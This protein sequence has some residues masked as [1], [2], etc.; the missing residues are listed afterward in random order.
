[1]EGE[2]SSGLAS[3]GI[4]IASAEPTLNPAWQWQSVLGT[5][6]RGRTS[7]TP[8]TPSRFRP[9]QRTH[10]GWVFLAGFGFGFLGLRG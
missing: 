1:M 9:R 5:L 7:T 4:A 6:N 3:V 10:R 2:K 8:S